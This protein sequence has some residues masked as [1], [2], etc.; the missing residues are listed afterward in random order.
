MK[1]GSQPQGSIRWLKAS[2]L[3]RRREPNYSAKHSPKTTPAPPDQRLSPIIEHI[4]PISESVFDFVRMLL[5]ILAK[6]GDV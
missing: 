5:A 2:R 4:V 6:D 1:G 3:W